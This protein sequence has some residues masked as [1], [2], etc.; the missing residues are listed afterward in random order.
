MQNLLNNFQKWSG[1]TVAARVVLLFQLLT[2]YPL[3]AYML[4][5][6]LLASICKTFNIS[7]V[8][9]V[10]VILITICIL[11]AVFVPYIGTIIRYTGALSGFIYIFTLPSLL[12]LAILKQQKKL[13]TF[14][15]L[16]HISIPII[17]FLNLLAQFFITESWEH[18]VWNS[19][20]WLRKVLIR[21][22]KTF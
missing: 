13:T 17:G 19:R 1:L 11:F 5:V 21:V 10:N 18:F 14:S 15:M 6:Q 20:K 22:P 16:L 7:C 2:V 4:R 9:L 12:Y 3:L 8:I